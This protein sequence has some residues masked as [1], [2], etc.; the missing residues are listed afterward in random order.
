MGKSVLD[1]GAWDGFFSFEAKRRGADRVLAT[2]NWAWTK[3]ITK[4]KGFLLARSALGL[5]VEQQLLGLEDISLSS[6]GTFDV[7]LLLGVIYHLPDPFLHIRRLAEVCTG[8]MIIETI[9]SLDDSEPMMKFY[10]FDELHG[11][12]SNW[13]AP[14]KAC[15][16]GMLQVSGFK[17]VSSRIN[18]HA[19]GKTG[20]IISHAT[21]WQAEDT[22]QRVVM[23]NDELKRVTRLV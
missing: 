1:I 22:E 6:I 19:N 13:W 8:T 4:D 23:L 12:F 14:N 9:I 21:K 11:D 3:H 2:D 5:S 7:V 10:P 18:P 15:L 17:S 20:R 16:E